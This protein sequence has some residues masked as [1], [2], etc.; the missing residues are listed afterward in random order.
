MNDVPGALFIDIS[1]SRLI[2]SGVGK[3]YGFSVNSHSGGTLK[4]IDGLYNGV[5]ASQTLT[6]DTTNV[7][8]GE[9]VTV[10]TVVYRFKNTLA[11]AYDVKI[12]ATAALSLANLKAAMNG[13]GLVG[14]DYFAGTDPHPT[15]VAG[16]IAAT[17]LLV[18][19]YKL[20]T[21]G[22]AI[23]T[24]ETSAHLSWGA[25]TLASGTGPTGRVMANTFTFATGS[26]NYRFPEP[27]NFVT[28]LLAVLGGT[29]ADITLLYN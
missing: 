28:A 29:S 3:V 15:C 4:L 18:T 21:V 24:T 5:A 25:A 16:T 27:I 11:A 8:D 23:A 9:T 7:S 12:A 6:S 1:D 19:Y 17:T 22:N 26:T 10:D 13:S 14:T 2:K 20:G